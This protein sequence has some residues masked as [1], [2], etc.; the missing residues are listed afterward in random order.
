M[1]VRIHIHFAVAAD[2]S[3]N[4]G[5]VALFTTWLAFIAAL[6]LPGSEITDAGSFLVSAV[7]GLAIVLAGFAAASRVRPIQARSNRDRAQ[8]AAF[9]LTLGIVGG[10]A[11]LFANYAIAS[12]DPVLEQ[13]LVS[14]FATLGPLVGLVAAPITEEVTVRLFLMSGLAWLVSHVTKTR[15]L[16]FGIAVVGASLVFAA[17]HLDRPMPADASLAT[18]Y[19]AALMVK[20][21]VISTLLGWAFWRL[22]LPYAILCHA[23]TNATH[24]VIEPMVFG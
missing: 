21:T 15:S 8:Y 20:Y 5:A 1:Q 9:A 10:L 23:T 7:V 12:R 18:L 6:A 16:A 11:N 3:R 19:R 4:E 17:L 14:R 24:M 13:L 2:R 22:G